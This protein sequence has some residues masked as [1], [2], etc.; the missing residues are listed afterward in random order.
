MTFP[1][2]RSASIESTQ[3]E[4]EFRRRHQAITHRMVHRKSSAIMYNKILERTFGESEYAQVG[5]FLVVCD[6][7]AT[8]T[9]RK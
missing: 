7:S 1:L 3:S 2:R 4:R 8:R 6:K 5:M 9:N